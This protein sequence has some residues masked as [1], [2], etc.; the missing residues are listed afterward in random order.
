MHT[1]QTEKP[2]VPIWSKYL[3]SVTIFIPQRWYDQAKDIN[4]ANSAL[5]IDLACELTRR[6]QELQFEPEGHYPHI[7]TLSTLSLISPVM[8]KC[9]FWSDMPISEERKIQIRSFAKEYFMKDLD[10]FFKHWMAKM[11]MIGQ[12]GEV[13]EYAY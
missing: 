13:Y 7:F 5:A 10:L 4:C 2:N 9:I 8:G 11:E 6:S 1:T 12:E 3:S